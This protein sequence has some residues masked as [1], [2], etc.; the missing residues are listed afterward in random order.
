MEAARGPWH[1]RE[2]SYQYGIAGEWHARNEIAGSPHVVVCENCSETRSMSLG[3]RE[4]RGEGQAAGGP[5]S[6]G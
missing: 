5:A 4:F 1:F 2:R 6:Q 3:G